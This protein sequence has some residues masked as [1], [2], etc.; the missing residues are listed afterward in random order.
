[1]PSCLHIYGIPHFKGGE[2]DRFKDP[3]EVSTPKSKIWT[4]LKTNTEKGKTHG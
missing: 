3:I 1:M 2:I 4:N